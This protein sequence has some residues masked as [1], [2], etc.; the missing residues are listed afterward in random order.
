LNTARSATAQAPAW[1]A[2][3]PGV[4]VFLWST[5]FIGAKYGLP[6]AEPLTFLLLRFALVLAILLPLALLVRAP[7][8]DSPGQALHYAAGGVLVH[9]GYLGGVF[10]AIHQGL[11]AGIAAMIAG[12]QP[13]LTAI[14]AG[15]LLGERINARQWSGFGLGLA[16]C[17]MVI[18]DKVSLQSANW[19][20]L[21]L[22]FLALFSLTAGTL[23]QKRFCAQ[24]DIR[25]GGVIQF[26]AAGLVLL[27][28]ALATE[29]MQVHWSPQFLLALCWMVFVMS[30]GAITLLYALIRHGEAARVSSLLYLVPASTAAIAFLVF[31]E[32]LGA[33]A[34]A[35][36]AVAAA[37]VWLVRGRNGTTEDTEEGQS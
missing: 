23:Y 15:P 34:L 25:S 8:P 9:A 31:D 35:G 29:T 4:F 24:M 13:V 5:G 16:G 7:W 33:L 18:L 17:W 37:G 2:V 6:Y 22:A 1:I 14:A 27:P 19:A 26:T 36:F 3:A 30:F 12:L 10:G 11:P 32:R 21:A 28:F 20:G